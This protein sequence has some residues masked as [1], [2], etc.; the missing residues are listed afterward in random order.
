MKSITEIKHKL[1]S[2]MVAASCSLAFASTGGEF[3]QILHPVQDIMKC[4]TRVLTPI[5]ERPFGSSLATAHPVPVKPH[6]AATPPSSAL[7]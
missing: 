5:H 4:F 3:L 6:S 2:N 1:T 7:G